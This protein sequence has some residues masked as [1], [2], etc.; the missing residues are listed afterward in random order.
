MPFDAVN[1]ATIA[2]AS[3]TF[4]LASTASQAAGQRRVFSLEQQQQ[5][6]QQHLPLLLM[7][8]LVLVY[9][10][11][12][13]VLLRRDHYRRQSDG[14]ATNQTHRSRRACHTSSS[15]YHC[16]RKEGSWEGGWE[17]G[18]L[19]DPFHLEASSSNAGGGSTSGVPIASLP[20]LDDRPSIQRRPQR[21]HH[22]R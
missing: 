10:D 5:Q 3:R 2:A 8:L 4:L 9:G 6:Q 19:L 12:A 1:A 22:Q 11:A 7:L 13:S 18:R 14:N 15:C 16:C 20:L 17:E 21:C